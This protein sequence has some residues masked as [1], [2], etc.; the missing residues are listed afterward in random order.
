MPARRIEQI[1]KCFLAI[2]AVV[3]IVLPTLLA[4]QNPASNG[5]LAFEAASIKPNTS[6]DIRMGIGFAPGGRLTVTNETL[7]ELVRF[8]YQIQRF[9]ILG[10][11]AWITSDR[12]DITAKAEQA[13]LPG[14]N[15]LPPELLQMLR[16]LLA[17]R[18]NLR[19]HM[20]TR[21]LPT[22]SLVMAR[23]DGKPGAGLRSVDVDCAAVLAARRGGGPPPLLPSR[24]AL[25]QL[26][27][28]GMLF[29]PGRLMAGAMSMTELVGGL[30]PMVGRLVTDR[31]GLLGRFEVNLEFTPEQMPPSRTG[32]PPMP[33]IDPNG[34]TIFTALQ[35]QLGLKLEPARAPVDVLMIDRAEHPTPD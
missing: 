19:T 9:Q 13:Y 12:F 18:F 5:T 35:E 17:E 26:P 1:M 24:G 14:P 16:M 15:G 7:F 21:D 29:G 28:C 23:S 4:R 31:T 11:P 10:G 3:T 25:P 33:P 34:P 8:A 6:G 2:S 32:G 27:V 20:E 30:M 22:Y